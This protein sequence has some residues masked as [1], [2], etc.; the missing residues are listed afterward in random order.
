MTILIRN[1]ALGMCLLS[2]LNGCAFFQLG[3][4]LKGLENVFALCGKITNAASHEK[5]ILIVLYQKTQEEAVLKKAVIIHPESGDFCLKVNQGTYNIGA[6]EDLNNNLEHDDGEPA[7]YYGKPDAIYVTGAPMDPK[8]PKTK[9]G[10]DFAVSA[11]TRLPEGYHGE[12]KLTNEI[13]QQSVIKMGELIDFDSKIM[14]QEYGSKGYWKPLTFLREVGIGIFFME[15]YDEDKIPILFV[16]GAVGTPLG[17]KE[18]IENINR[19]RYQPWFYYYPS[20]L[21]LDRMG[22]ALN[23][24]VNQLHDRYD[25]DEMI[26]VAQSMGG[27]VARSFIMKS[28]HESKQDFIK[29]FISVSTPW[30]GHRMTEKGVKRAPTAVPSWYDMVPGSEFIEKLYENKLP[31]YLKHY[32][33]F[34]YKGDCSLFLAN[35]DGTVELSSEL[36]HRAQNEAYRIIG[37]NED[38]GSIVFSEKYLAKIQE[39]FGM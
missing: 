31:L 36:D 18:T 14:A 13:V 6:F 35:N 5:D 28:V 24:L 12:I 4:E 34:S 38:H 37:Y 17:W 3:K 20:G 39:L 11:S 15:E 29:M 1:L 33:L 19:D 30:N 21:P 10:L 2:L 32:L 16:H 7:G 25:F 22:E 27:L 23:T 9:M 8:H 26:V